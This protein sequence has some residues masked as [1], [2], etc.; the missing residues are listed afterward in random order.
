VKCFFSALSKHTAFPAWWNSLDLEAQ[1][2][3]IDDI[4]EELRFRL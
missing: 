2:L 4:R 3:V 1:K